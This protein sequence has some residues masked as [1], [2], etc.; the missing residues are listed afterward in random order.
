MRNFQVEHF[1]SA[2]LCGAQ[3]CRGEVTGW[4]DLPQD[5]KDAYGE[6]VAPY[7]RQMDVDAAA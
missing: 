7:L 5:R 2:C 3:N 6:L 1:P 4:Q